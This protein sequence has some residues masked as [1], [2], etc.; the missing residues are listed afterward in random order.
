MA[1]QNGRRANRRMLKI[2]GKHKPKVF[3][4]TCNEITYR[5]RASP[6]QTVTTLAVGVAGGCI[7][8]QGVMQTIAVAS[9]EEAIANLSLA[10]IG[11]AYVMAGAIRNLYE[12]LYHKKQ[13]SDERLPQSY[14]SPARLQV[15]DTISKI[16]TFQQYGALDL[17]RIINEKCNNPKV[18]HLLFKVLLSEIHEVVDSNEE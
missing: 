14:V 12:Q 2:K 5:L 17:R 15:T 1:H 8:V 16:V 7:A 11:G 6:I 4:M 13:A 18:I 10:H 3:L 9:T